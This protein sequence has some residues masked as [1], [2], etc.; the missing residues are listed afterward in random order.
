MLSIIRWWLFEKGK[1]ERVLFEIAYKRWHFDKVILR[2]RFIIISGMSDFEY[3]LKFIVV[4]DTGTQR[5]M[6]ES[7]RAVSSPSS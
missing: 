2:C 5:S 3:L 7:A 6:Q 1:G 4:G